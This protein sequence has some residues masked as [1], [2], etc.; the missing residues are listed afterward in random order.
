MSL[1]A[2]EAGGWGGVFTAGVGMETHA[3]AKLSAI[4]SANQKLFCGIDTIFSFRSGT[5]I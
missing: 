2:V 5:R 3:A 1:T 4:I